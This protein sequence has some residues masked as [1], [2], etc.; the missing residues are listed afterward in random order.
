MD[1]LNLDAT[2]PSRAAEAVVR[3]LLT[4]PPTVL[5]PVEM[6]GRVGSPDEPDYL[7]N[8]RDY[9]GD[10]IAQAKL[11]PDS[12]ILDIGCGCGRIATGF[13]RFLSDK[14]SY[15]GFDVWS[16]GVEWCTEHISAVRPN[17]AFHVVDAHNNY[18]HADDTGAG[19]HF[20]LSF[21]PDGA[22]DCVFALS[23]FTHLKLPDARQYLSLVRRA[24]APTGLAY[25]TFFLMDEH[26]ERYIRETGQHRWLQPLGN[27]MWHAYE[28][29]HFFAGYEESF[30]M[31]Q[32]DEFGLDIVDRSLGR[33]ADKPGARVF[34]DWFL[35]R[36][37]A[38]QP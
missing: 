21:V 9:V 13:A 28:R 25:L 34:Q 15:V 4:H 37:R 16:E 5:P 17:F 36:P 14:A 19:N 26:V 6:M 38:P 32:F 3:S 18:Y 2:S 24:L 35:L 22:F 10:L 11:T 31:A 20:G 7:L 29:Q 8:I 12:R 30:L 27:G 33:W 1:A 23:V